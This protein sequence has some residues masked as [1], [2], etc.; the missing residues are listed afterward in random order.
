M[1]KKRSNAFLHLS[2]PFFDKQRIGDPI[3]RSYI[4]TPTY[5]S[6]GEVK[7]TA[8]EVLRHLFN[9]SRIEVLL[10]D[11]LIRP[12]IIIGLKIQSNFLYSFR[13]NDFFSFFYL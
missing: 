10:F 6:K 4:H 1:P 2:I 13:F 11:H 8:F 5:A 3:S 12:N 9:V 7:I